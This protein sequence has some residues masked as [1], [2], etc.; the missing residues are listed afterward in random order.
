M[1]GIT[2]RS[3]RR[4]LPLALALVALAGCVSTT[5]PMT[6]DL[7]RDLKHVDPRIRIDSAL[8]VVA[9]GRADPA[10]SLGD[11]PHDPDRAPT[12][13]AVTLEGRHF[14]ARVATGG[15]GKTPRPEV[16]LPQRPAGGA[17]RVAER[18]IVTTDDPAVPELTVRATASFSYRSTSTAVPSRT[19]VRPSRVVTPTGA[20]RRLPSVRTPSTTT[21]RPAGTTAPATKSGSR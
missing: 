11:T 19:R 9:E 4:T 10:S 18:V 7:R 16:S 14:Q 13:A 12:P 17:R 21:P 20:P 6:G 5:S 2:S 15:E 8:A 3:R 1:Q